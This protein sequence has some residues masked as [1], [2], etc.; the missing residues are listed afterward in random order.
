MNPFAKYWNG[1]SERKQ[2]GI[3]YGGILLVF[4]LTLTFIISVVSYLFTW[5]QDQ[6]ALSAASR[7]P[8]LLRA[9]PSAISWSRKVSAWRPSA[10]SFSC[11]PGA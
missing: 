8:P 6:S 2:T 1:L 9:F 3:R 11:W 4:I 5:K 7:M 10:S